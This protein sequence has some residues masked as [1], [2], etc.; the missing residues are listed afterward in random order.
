MIVGESGPKLVFLGRRILDVESATVGY[1]EDAMNER[2][3]P[4]QH[5]YP[6]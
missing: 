6:P 3:A 2:S 5:T 1:V 4:L